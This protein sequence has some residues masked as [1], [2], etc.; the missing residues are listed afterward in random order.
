MKASD[1]VLRKAYIHFRGSIT[2]PA[3]RPAMLSGQII[4]PQSKLSWDH[5]RQRWWR[6]LGN[7]PAQG[8]SEQVPAT[9]WGSEQNSCRLR[10]SEAI[11]CLRRFSTEA[12]AARRKRPWV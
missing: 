6:G 9:A 1:L 8:S 7:G 4:R 3:L 10:G 5:I 12:P 11:V 2:N